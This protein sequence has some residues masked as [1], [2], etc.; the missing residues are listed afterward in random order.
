[1]TNLEQTI[2]KSFLG[3]F[4]DYFGRIRN[5]AV[6]KIVVYSLAGVL[7]AGLGYGCGT[8]VFAYKV[9]SNI[10]YLG[11]NYKMITPELAQKEKLPLEKGALIYE[12]PDNPGVTP[13]SPADYA[14]LRTGDIIIE[15]DGEKITQN[16]VLGD[17]IKKH[18][19]ADTI[20]LKVLRGEKEIE[21]KAILERRQYQEEIEFCRKHSEIP[22][23]YVKELGLHSSQIKN[24]GYRVLDHTTF[25]NC[26]TGLIREADTIS[27]TDESEAKDA[28]YSTIPMVC[29]SATTFDS[30]NESGEII[31]PWSGHTHP[32]FHKFYY[33]VPDDETSLNAVRDCIKFAQTE[34]K[35]TVSTGSGH[36]S[37][38]YKYVGQDVTTQEHEQTSV[39]KA[40]DE[41]QFKVCLGSIK[42]SHW[43]SS[44]DIHR[45]YCEMDRFVMGKF[46]RDLSKFKL[47][48]STNIN[49]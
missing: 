10:P 42:G 30:A 38:Y 34:H 45:E 36:V 43:F 21:V 22:P 49:R 9:P 7:S 15:L 5:S 8:T 24:F 12:T 20:T 6:S 26:I 39:K 32:I 28:G 31:V 16:N 25:N 33:Y 17:V 35:T 19:V 44:V 2:E 4:K 11:T 47:L 3:R 48:Q 13:H 29:K 41:E 1:M 23:H 40:I 46:G 18:S 27:C 37:P 14:G